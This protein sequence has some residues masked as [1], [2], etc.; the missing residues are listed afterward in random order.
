MIDRFVGKYRF[1]SNFF[2]E[3]DDT[4]VEGEYQWAK[5]IDPL[6]RFPSLWYE[7]LG[8]EEMGQNSQDKRRLGISEDEH[9]GGTCDEEIY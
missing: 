7:S 2:I 3:P 4:H 9:Y 1:L 6:Q 8:S 5:C